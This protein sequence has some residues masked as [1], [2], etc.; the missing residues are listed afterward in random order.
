MHIAIIVRIRKAPI[1]LN[2]VSSK[3]SFKRLCLL[4]LKD[5]MFVSHKVKQLITKRVIPKIT[6]PIKG[7]I[8]LSAKANML[9]SI[10]QNMLIIVK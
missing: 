3:Y 10:V 2:G 1:K 4:A 6:I 8:S 9:I 5:I 7:I